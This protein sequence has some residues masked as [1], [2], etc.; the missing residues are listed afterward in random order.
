M[1]AYDKLIGAFDE[2]TYKRI[3]ESLNDIS[4]ADSLEIVTLR[5]SP[6]SRTCH[7]RTRAGDTTLIFDKEKDHWKYEIYGNLA[8]DVF[9]RD[10]LNNIV[11]KSAERIGATA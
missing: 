4:I 7:V 8:A 10:R 2:V 9:T 6:I 11:E 3:D 1:A 5:K